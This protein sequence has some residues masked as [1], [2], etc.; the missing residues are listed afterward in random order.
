MNPQIPQIATPKQL[1]WY[2][3]ALTALNAVGVETLVAGG[4]ATF[5]YTRMWPVD[6][7]SSE[8]KDLDLTLVENCVPWA[9]AALNRAGF[10]DYHAKEAYQQH[11][12]YRAVANEPDE[13]GRPII[14]DLIWQK[15]N[16]PQLQRQAGIVDTSWFLEA[17]QSDYLS[18]VFG[19]PIQVIGP[20]DLIF[21]KIYV[22]QV[23]K[24]H[25]PHIHNIIVGTR[26]QL[27][28][29]RLLSFIGE[30]WRLLASFINFYDWVNPQ[31]REFIPA[32]VMR[33]LVQLTLAATD[34]DS[35]G[36]FDRLDTRDWALKRPHP[37]IN[38]QI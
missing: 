33:Q 19:H 12:I 30:D 11:W 18:E 23:S 6:P 21:S 16:Q 25:W 27:N 8:P 20:A 34:I 29:E 28:W 38:S 4:Y 32:S 24:N 31:L 26:G 35:E 14:V 36:R 15:A 7:V 9:V 37:T 10:T 17:H 2:G 3:R 22:F 1:A 5:H 13:Q